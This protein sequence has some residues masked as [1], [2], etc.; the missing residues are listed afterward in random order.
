M[1]TEGANLVSFQHIDG[2]CTNFDLKSELNKCFIM[3]FFSPDWLSLSASYVFCWIVKKALNI[4][5]FTHFQV[6]FIF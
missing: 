1:V 4:K 3:S 2:I 5:N 6:T